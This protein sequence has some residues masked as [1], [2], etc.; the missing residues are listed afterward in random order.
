MLLLPTLLPLYI[1]ASS[2]AAQ[3][4]APTTAACPSGLKAVRAAGQVAAK[5]QTLSPEE[6]A[7]VLGHRLGPGYQGY[8]SYYQSVQGAFPVSSKDKLPAY[9]G[10]IL[11]SPLEPV[12]PLRSS[13]G[14]ER[15][16][17]T[18]DRPVTVRHARDWPS[19]LL[20]ADTAQL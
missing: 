18:T 11:T 7:Y 15:G 12:C 9:V 14:R 6:A 19:P 16:Q 4:Y 13:T 8:L 1:A 10:A 2:V 5:N 20:E 17:L 3:T